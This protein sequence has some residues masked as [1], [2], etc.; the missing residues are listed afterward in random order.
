MDEDFLELDSSFPGPRTPTKKGKSPVSFSHSLAKRTPSSKVANQF[1]VTGVRDEVVAWAIKVF[2]EYDPSCAGELDPF[3]IKHALLESGKEVSDALVF[4]MMK[5]IGKVD[6]AGVKVNFREFVLMCHKQF[7]PEID[8]TDETK[9][10]REAFQ[11]LGGGADGDG[12]VSVD[13]LREFTNSTELTIDIDQFVAEVD[14][15]QSGLVDYGEFCKLFNDRKMDTNLHDSG[16]YWLRHDLNADP[17]IPTPTARPKTPT[18]LIIDSPKGGSPTDDG[19]GTKQSPAGTLGSRIHSS[20]VSPLMDTV[21]R[22]SPEA[23]SGILAAPPR[24]PRLKKVLQAQLP[25]LD[26]RSIPNS[27]IV[28]C[29][30]GWRFSQLRKNIPGAEGYN[31]YNIKSSQWKELSS[32][33][34][35][36]SRG[37]EFSLAEQASERLD[38]RLST[39]LRLR[40][41]SRESSRAQTA[42]SQYTRPQTSASQYPRIQTAASQGRP[43]SRNHPS[44]P[45]K[46]PHSRAS[47]NPFRYSARNEIEVS[48]HDMSREGVRTVAHGLMINAGEGSEGRGG[49][50]APRKIRTSQQP[51][52]HCP[53]RENMRHA[54]EA[55]TTRELLARASAVGLY[56][57]TGVK[58]GGDRKSVV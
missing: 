18:A 36:R 49:T 4:Q 24:A 9:D 21:R 52:R 28:T 13:K 33:V 37:A 38:V 39:E 35:M 11:I 53:W 44:P 41:V 43:G 12:Q 47:G 26:R 23:E 15:D 46:R 22:R 1:D 48:A 8:E 34:K 10:V 57:G 54:K 27:T 7:F 2:S 55:L 14:D 16:E 40:K 17:T 50:P 58:D 30:R 42:A 6:H 5:S 45:R 56:A 19:P 20:I 29:R 3:E 32:V 51:D 25:A 31:T